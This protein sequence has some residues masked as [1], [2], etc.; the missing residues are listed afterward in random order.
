MN[1]GFKDLL[2]ESVVDTSLGIF[3][4]IEVENIIVDQDLCVGG[5]ILADLINEKTLDNGVLIE[6][7]LLKDGLVQGEDLAADLQFHPH[8]DVRTTASPAFVA[9]D[10]S[11]DITVDFI[12]EFTPGEGVTVEGAILKDTTLFLGTDSTKNIST[13]QIHIRDTGNAYIFLEADTDNI[14]NSEHALIHFAQDA[15]VN[16]FTC[17]Q[18]IRN[19]PL[20]P[21]ANAFNIAGYNTVGFNSE[22]RFSTGGTCTATTDGTLPV[23]TIQSTLFLRINQNDIKAFTDYNLDTGLTYNLDGVAVIAGNAANTIAIGAGTHNLSGVNDTLIGPNATT[24]IS[25]SIERTS[26]GFNAQAQNDYDVQLGERI[27]NGSGICFYRTQQIAREDW[28]G[29][30]NSLATITNTGSIDRADGTEDLTINNLD[31]TGILTVDTINES[32]LG[33]GVNI[34]NILFLNGLLDGI[35]ISLALVDHPHQSV[36]VS[37]SPSFVNLNIDTGGTYDIN[38]VAIVDVT[39]TNNLGL[40]GGVH[41]LTAQDVTFVGFNAGAVNTSTDTTGISSKCLES[42]TTGNG[43]TG[44]GHLCLNLN[45]VGDR[46]TSAGCRASRDQVLANDVSSFGTDCLRSNLASDN[47]SFGSKAS[48]FCVLGQQNSSFGC[49]TLRN[50]INSSDNAAYGFKCMSD[51]TTLQDNCGY[52]HQCMQRATV[53]ETCSFGHNSLRNVTA[54]LNHAFGWKSQ[55][56][57]IVGVGN[58]SFGHNCLHANLGNSNS[59]FG[60]NCLPLLNSGSGGNNAYGQS[61]MANATSAEFNCGYG[62]FNL[63]ALTSGAKNCSYGN[64]SLG[65]LTTS[66]SNSAFGNGSGATIVDGQQNTLIGDLSDV[67]DS[68]AI[69]RVAIGFSAIAANNFD[70]QLGRDVD[71]GSGICF[72]RSQQIA[73]EDWIGGSASLAVI[74]SNGDIDRS[75][76]TEDVTF[77]SISTDVI[78]EDTPANGV[79]VDNLL[80][81]DGTV[82]FTGSDQSVLSIYEEFNS[83]ISFSGPWAAPVVS[84]VHFTRVGR[85]VT[86]FID[87]TTS[88][89]TVGSSII[90]AAIP[91]RF[92]PTLTS[93]EQRMTVVDN[94]ALV[95]GRLIMSTAGAIQI[96]VGVSSAFV[97]ALNTGFL[98]FSFTYSV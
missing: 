94:V 92:R 91:V 5:E 47:S 24:S 52:G 65:N 9:I 42:N 85:L 73:R 22:I 4:N 27:D 37:S 35:D 69:E 51:G 58:S 80:I 12:D 98:G 15:N 89:A 36:L 97:G 88:N 66:D 39:G 48:Q 1:S 57:N 54:T 95:T 19:E 18:G 28:I 77:G 63:L 62:L 10:V 31:V 2:N 21:A 53:S 41:N 45:T 86:L 90:G 93:H 70:V 75:L 64:S 55:E 3:E 83:S 40:G 13:A 79:L 6:N 38:N 60:S 32:T 11:D 61:C 56:D 16:Y 8:Q 26:L 50:V 25:G 29:N 68:D 74:D 7:V 23:I 17:G 82:R 67:A 14:N 72:F 44:T 34:E 84:T 20:N 46:N 96:F 71:G 76:G 43:N 78:S 87:S 59:G 30:G 49:N 81:R 33:Q